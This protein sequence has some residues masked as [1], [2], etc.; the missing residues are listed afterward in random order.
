MRPFFSRT[1]DRDETGFRIYAV[2]GDINFHS[3]VPPS[4]RVR[5]GVY[6]HFWPIPAAS[7]FNLPSFLRDAEFRES[8]NEREVE[9]V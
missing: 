7:I 6:G 5:V 3:N 9:D 4:I 2:I 1:D 8:E